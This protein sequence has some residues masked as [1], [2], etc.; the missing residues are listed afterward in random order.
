MRSSL[1]PLTT[2]LVLAAVALAGAAPAASAAQDSS[3]V[4]INTKDDSS[5]FKLAFSLKQ[6]SGDVVDQTNAAVAYASCSNCQTVAIAIQVVLV[7]SENPT[8]VVPENIA[9]AI[10]QNCSV[11]TTM[12]MAYQFVFGADDPVRLTAEGRRELARIRHALQE[13]GKQEGLSPDEIIAQTNDLVDQLREVLETELVP[14]DEGNGA[15]ES[16]D[17][18][19]EGDQ[20]EDAGGDST[21]PGDPEQP[22]EATTPVEPPTTEAQPEAEPQ[23]QQG[24]SSSPAP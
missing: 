11:C 21:Q 4:A 18:E 20:G 17:G 9:L 2:A 24:D 23:P 8:S 5:I 7:M 15:D 22:P 13:L 1:R 16:E 6:V 12:A 3:A 14:L 19:R 10:N